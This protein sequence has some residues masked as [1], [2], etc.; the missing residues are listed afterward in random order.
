MNKEN[1]FMQEAIKLAKKAEGFTS[2]NPLVGAV[3]VKNNRIVS[4][5]YHRRAGTPHAEINAI[6]RAKPSLVTSTIYL[7]LEPCYHFGRTPPCVDKIIKEKF[8]KVVIATLDPN[9]LVGGKS[10]KKLKKAGIKVKVGILK[11]EAQKLNEV[12]F[13]NMKENMPF[14]VAKAAQS[15]DGKIAT[16][17]GISKWITSKRARNYSK[18]LRDKYDSVL[19]GINTVIKDNPDLNGLKRAPVKIVID[20][21]LKLSLKTNL[22]KKYHK[23][24]IVITSDKSKRKAKRMRGIK[25]VLFFKMKNKTIPLREVL[26]KLYSLGITSVFVE[27]GSHTLGTFFDA[28]LIDKAYF[29]IAPIVIGGKDSLASIGGKGYLEPKSACRLEKL[30]LIPIGG[31]LLICGYP[32]YR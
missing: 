23:K 24:L 11:Q 31:D 20:P 28:R 26:R 16:S 8:K 19:V 7:N 22:Y 21:D 17:K 2:P 13:K 27:G 32:K 18:S 14:V 1:Y 9:P 15:L 4:S 5:G 25:N 10:L 30:E 29:F 3:I 6:K 12:F